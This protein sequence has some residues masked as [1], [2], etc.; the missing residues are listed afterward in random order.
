MSLLFVTISFV[1]GLYFLRNNLVFS[2]IISLVYVVFIFI[3]FPKKKACLFLLVFA[4]GALLG[5]I[6]LEYN[7][8]E[9]VYQG[10]VVDVKEN[11]FIFQSRFEKFYVYEEATTKEFGD[12]LTIK[13][14]PTDFKST[15]YE[16]QFSFADYLKDKGVKRS[17]D[18]K[19]YSI[20][21]ANP[22]RIHSQ[23]VNFLNRFDGSAKAMINALLFNEKD[24]SSEAIKTFD[25]LNLIYLVSVS[26]IYLHFIFRATTYVFGLYTS[27]K[28][29]EAVPI[30][31]FSPLAIFAFPRISILRIF[32][33][34]S[35]K[36]VNDHF[37]KKRFSYLT[38]L[39]SLALFFLILDFHLAYQQA[40]YIGFLLSLLGVFYRTCIRVFPERKRKYYLAVSAYL[41][42]FPF[43]CMNQ[44]SLHLL[45]YPFQL[46]LTPF[47]VL[48]I[49][50]SLISVVNIPIYSFVN[51]Y[52]SF[53]VG[54]AKTLV[55]LDLQLP[56]KVNEWFFLCYYV[57]LVMSLYL[58]EGQRFKHLR[59]VTIALVCLISIS[60][61]LIQLPTNSIYFIN[62]GQGDSILIVNRFKTVMIDTGGNT[63]FDM[64]EETL[65]PFFQKKGINHLDL[66]VTTH[67]DFDHAGA[68]NS[69]I[70][71]FKVYKYLKDREDFPYKVGD[72]YLENINFYDGDA[73]DSSLVFLLNFMHKKWMLTGD[74]TSQT[75]QYILKSGI[76]V[77]CDIL[78]VGHHGSSTSS[79]ETFIKATSPSEAIISCGAKNRYGH[80]NQDVLD[81]LAKYNVK[82][83]RTDLEGTISYV[84]IFA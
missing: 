28:V 35:M 56:F 84:S 47:F 21:F 31:L 49:L 60:I 13:A 34:R 59:N 17:L 12:F 16:S 51:S 74:A 77:D 18:L 27:D 80:P 3:R 43:L 29:A 58:L 10:M 67:D 55:K 1:L 71:N 42:L 66:L 72:I 39:S 54:I 61:I 57:L 79:S 81:R 48:F 37:L 7:N 20:N 69:L 46:M 30:L 2:I 68:A 82:I 65:I 4:G 26:G 76:N 22:I 64:A 23:K 70:E 41:F 63:S 6:N 53:L 25:D 5:N 45:S 24:Y 78:K 75:E 44:Y 33:I 14:Q 40:F 9:N 73:N 62:V 38:L 19:D 32:M 15:T 11:Y 50:F 52:A 36:Y 83:R 8:D